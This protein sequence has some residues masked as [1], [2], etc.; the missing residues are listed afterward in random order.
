M[1]LAESKIRSKEWANGRGDIEG[2]PQYFI[3]QAQRIGE[4][5]GVKVVVIEGDEL[6]EK[7]FRL[8]HAVGRA[9]VNKPA[10]VNLSYNGNPDSQDWL[11]FVGKGV[12]FDSGGLDIK[13]GN[14]MIK[15]S[16]WNVEHVLG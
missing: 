16:C 11:A 4:Q 3:K 14:F 2:T 10:F 12:C 13:P 9:S 7:G 8:L 1:S 15:F 5:F 6:I